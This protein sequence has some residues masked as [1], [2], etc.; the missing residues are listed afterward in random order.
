[1]WNYSIQYWIF[2]SRMILTSL[3]LLISQNYHTQCITIESNLLL[4]LKSIKRFT[5]GYHVQNKLYYFYQLNEQVF[6]HR[7]MNGVKMVCSSIIIYQKSILLSSKWLD[8]ITYITNY[9]FLLFHWEKIKKKKISTW[10]NN[11]QY[12][13]LLKYK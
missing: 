3:L 4:R 1:M 6:Y 7:E 10:I 12:H 9:I 11:F 5:T 2:F 8:A 13:K